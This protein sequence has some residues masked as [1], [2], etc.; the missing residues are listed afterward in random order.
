MR[1]LL[2][3]LFVLQGSSGDRN[4]DDSDAGNDGDADVQQQSPLE[5]P[6][7]LPTVQGKEEAA[8][9]AQIF[10]YLIRCRIT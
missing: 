5:H 4:D 9:R 3:A 7:E 10:S 1:F 2:M 8:D 6:L